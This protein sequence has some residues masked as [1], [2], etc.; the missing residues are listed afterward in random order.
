MKGLDWPSI[1]AEDVVDLNRFSV[2]LTS[3]ASSCGGHASSVAASR[4]KEAA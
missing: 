1:K 2:F 3:K 4:A